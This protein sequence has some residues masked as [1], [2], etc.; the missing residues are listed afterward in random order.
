[1]NE[2]CFVLS[3]VD[4]EEGRRCV[5]RGCVMRG[6]ALRKCIMKKCVMRGGCALIHVL[7]R[8]VLIKDD[9]F[10]EKIFAMMSAFRRCFLDDN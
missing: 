10:L 6:C 8:E 3:L 4:V 1:M 2:L 7:S 5:M 9:Q